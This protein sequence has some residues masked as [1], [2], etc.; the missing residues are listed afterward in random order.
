MVEKLKCSFVHFEKRSSFFQEYLRMLHRNSTRT[1][2]G[3]IFRRILQ[4]FFT[5]SR[6][7]HA[8]VFLLTLMSAILRVVNHSAKTE[9]EEHLEHV[10]WI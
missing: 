7:E 3:E 1:K 5:L 4:T 2:E 9:E 8:T 6:E 10:F